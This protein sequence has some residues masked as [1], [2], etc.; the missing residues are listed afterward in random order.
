[1]GDGDADLTLM[2]RLHRIGHPGGHL[3]FL[4]YTYGVYPACHGRAVCLPACPASALVSKTSLPSYISHEG[5]VRGKK[6]KKKKK[7]N[8]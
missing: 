6:K 2:A 8:A 5:M 1:M 7:K 3:L 4:C